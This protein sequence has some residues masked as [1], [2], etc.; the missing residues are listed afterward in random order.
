MKLLKQNS[1]KKQQLIDTINSQF[2]GSLDSRNTSY[3]S[4]NKTKAVWW[5][6]I[7]VSKF[8]QEVNLLFDAPDNEIWIVLPKGF[9]SNLD[10]TFRIRKDKNVVDLEISADRNGLYLK[11]VKSGGSGFDFGRYVKEKVAYEVK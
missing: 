5:I 9:V 7:S 11:D 10:S 6:N 1:S 2:G 4:I 3:A 8:E